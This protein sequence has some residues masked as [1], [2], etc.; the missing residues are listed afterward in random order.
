MR[1]DFV[2]VVTYHLNPTDVTAAFN[3]R[4]SGPLLNPDT[5]S[6]I[7]IVC[8]RCELPVSGPDLVGGECPGWAPG[9]RVTRPRSPAEVTG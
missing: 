9:P 3:A 6:D 7:A 1:H 4:P 5:L 8:W 2:A